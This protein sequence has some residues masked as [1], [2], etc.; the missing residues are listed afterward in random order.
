[1]KKEPTSSHSWDEKLRG[2]THIAQKCAI[3]QK[4]VRGLAPRLIAECSGSGNR[5][6]SISART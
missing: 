6:S 5:T 2:T 1:M 4:S 3:F